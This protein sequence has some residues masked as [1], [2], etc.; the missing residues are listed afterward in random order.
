[1]LVRCT[2]SGLAAWTVLPVGSR[3]L[4]RPVASETLGRNY[5][6]I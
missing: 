6:T 3:K 1:M 2:I 4:F 5:S